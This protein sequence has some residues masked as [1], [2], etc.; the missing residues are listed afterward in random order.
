MHLFEE[1]VK[2]MEPYA[3]KPKTL[4]SAHLWQTKPLRTSAHFTIFFF[5]HNTLFFHFIAVNSVH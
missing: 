2:G 4:Q 1:Q 3:M 5:A